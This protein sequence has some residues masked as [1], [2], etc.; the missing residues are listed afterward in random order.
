MIFWF[1]WSLARIIIFPILRVRV[2]GLHNIPRHQ[3]VIIAANHASEFDPIF[4]GCGMHRRIFFMAKME[5]FR[6]PVIGWFLRQ[7]GAF[8][9]RRGGADRQAIKQALGH[10]QEGRVLGIFPE[11]T[12]SRSGELQAPHTGVALLAI[13]AGVPVVPVAITGN[14]HLTVSKV[15]SRRKQR[16][17]VRYGA[18]LDPADFTAGLS[19]KEALLVFSQK[20]MEEIQKL[21]K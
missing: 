9:V 12:R 15:F 17:E 8:P 7:L 14:E 10:L 6:N 18:P 4:V 21:R 1:I 11:G 5:L 2:S 13:K 19:E 20:V 3:G 16:V